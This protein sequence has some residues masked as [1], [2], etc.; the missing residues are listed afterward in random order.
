MKILKSH[1]EEKLGNKKNIT[2]LGEQLTMLGLEVDSIDPIKKD[3]SIDIDLT[4]NRGDCFSVLGVA[5]E[6]AAD[7]QI[8]L[9]KE[10]TFSI[11]FAGK[12]KKKVNVKEPE[13]CPRYCLMEISNFSL[14]DTKGKL[15]KIPESINFRLENAGI[16]SVNPI[17]DLLNY[18]ML[19]IGQPMHAFDANKINGE[20]QVRFANKNEKITLLDDQKINLTADCL[21]IADEK[22]PLALAGVM[23]SLGS[24]VDI[25]T[26]SVI[27]L[28]IPVCVCVF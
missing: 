24:S 1:L 27:L 3:Y 28:A 2:K 7:E 6:I 10:K 20:L 17:V 19:D 16:N 9:K 14:K 4:P 11:D 12:P 15:K 22:N 13:A 5:R 26:N 23:G 8:K 25:E 21:L 18:V